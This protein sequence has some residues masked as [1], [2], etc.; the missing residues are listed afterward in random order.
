MVL[1]DLEIISQ[2][3]TELHIIFENLAAANKNIKAIF[4]TF[5]N[6][7]EQHRT[8]QTLVQRERNR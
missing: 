6:S 8:F 5:G 4:R 1:T 7:L 3:F 2:H